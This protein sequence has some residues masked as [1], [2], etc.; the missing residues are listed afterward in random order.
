MSQNKESH[1]QDPRGVLHQVPSMRR[2]ALEDSHW[3]DL[4]KWGLVMLVICLQSQLVTR[5]PP[6]S[7]RPPQII[8]FLLFSTGHN[9]M[10]NMYRGKNIAEK[11]KCLK[12]AT[13][14]FL[15]LNYFQLKKPLPG[16][17]N[18]TLGTRGCGVEQARARPTA[19]YTLEALRTVLRKKGRKQRAILGY[20]LQPPPCPP[21]HRP[22]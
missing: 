3:T 1:P 6:A 22:L 15:A 12:T 8:E 4:G 21:P 20:L 10:P 16:D 17:R 11:R 19:T 7:P 18:C 14:C 9:K 5:S 13:G 2:V